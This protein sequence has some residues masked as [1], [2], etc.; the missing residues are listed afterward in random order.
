MPVLDAIAALQRRL[1]D[2]G[3]PDKEA[4]LSALDQASDAVR[5]SDDEAE[6]GEPAR[7]VAALGEAKIALERVRAALEG[8]DPS[9]GHLEAVDKVAELIDARLAEYR[10]ALERLVGRMLLQEGNTAYVRDIRNKT[11]LGPPILD[12]GRLRVFLKSRSAQGFDDDIGDLTGTCG[13]WFCLGD[14]CVCHQWECTLDGPSGSF[15]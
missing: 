9:E 4:L 12:D 5:K 10:G 15:P 3:D 7:A 14:S 2:V 13:I 6:N 8:A 11:A 1:T